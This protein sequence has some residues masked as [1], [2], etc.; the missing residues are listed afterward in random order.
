L[1]GSPFSPTRLGRPVSD[2]TGPV[3]IILK[4]DGYSVPR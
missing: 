3:R 2:V 4:D 1:L